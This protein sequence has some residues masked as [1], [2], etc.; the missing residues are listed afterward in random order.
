MNVENSHDPCLI[1]RFY[2]EFCAPNCTLVTRMTTDS[3]TARLWSAIEKVFDQ[4][5]DDIAEGSIV[6][7]PLIP[8][9]IARIKEFQ[10][11][12]KQGERGS[13]ITG[14]IV[15]NSTMIY[16]IETAIVDQQ[17]CSSQT[18]VSTSP[19]N[20]FIFECASIRTGRKLRVPLK[21]LP[22]PYESSTDIVFTCHLDESHRM[23]LI[24]MSLF[25]K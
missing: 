23:Y 9:S 25:E 19:S 24:E 20:S 8:D 5:P 3:P 18:L 13:R 4:G 22:N 10:V 16:D 21:L 12:V 14:T 11:R 6:T 1:R 17:T 2:R 15:Y 7:Y